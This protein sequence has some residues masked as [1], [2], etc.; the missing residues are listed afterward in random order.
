MITPGPDMVFVTANSLAGGWRAGL[1][2]VFGVATG[3]YIHILAAAVGVSAIIAT[4]ELAYNAVRFG[5]A[6]YLAWI[7][8]K[9]LTTKTAFGNVTAAA[10]KPL[11][12]IFRQGVITNVMNP[13]AALFTLSFVPQFISPS[14]GP[15]WLQILILGVIICVIMILVELPIVLASG[16]LSERMAKSS[17]AGNLVGKAVGALLIGLAAYV[18]LARRPV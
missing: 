17:N 1:A 15:V 14:H 7:G 13:K 2:S 6:A 12:I 3:A 18:A 5:G 9:F 16:R 4:S 8:F 11:M 10:P